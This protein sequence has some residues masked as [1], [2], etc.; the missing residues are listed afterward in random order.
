[1]A[2]NRV[3][4]PS[5]NYSSRSGASVRI[6]VV[7]TAEGALTIESL[8]GWFANP[9]SQ[10]S[11]HVGI[12]DKPNTVGEY[13]RRPDKAW[14][15]ASYNPVAVSAELCGF[16]EWST[17]QWHQHPNMLANCAAWIAEEC[18]HWGIPIVRLSDAEAQS[19]GRGVC[20]HRSL[21]SG[22]GGHWDVGYNFPW[23]EVLAMA[24]G[25]A[26]PT[27]PTEEDDMAIFAL[28]NPDGRIEVFAQLTKD[29]SMWHAYQSSPGGGWAGSK[30]GQPV[31]WYAMGTPGK[32]D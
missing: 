15:Q 1:M 13:V 5:P 25:G 27:P 4:I 30:P 12:D 19:S 18:A 32:Q 11:S 31:Q 20:D 10:V 9:S 22:G 2:L 17:D 28:Q 29:D 21:G 3:W 24:R 8:G 23:D 26:Q 16:A 7:H 14:T 6:V